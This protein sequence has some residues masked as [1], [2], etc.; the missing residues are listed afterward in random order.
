MPDISTV[1]SYQW[2]MKQSPMYN[3]IRQKPATLRGQINIPTAFYPLFNFHFVLGY[4]PGDQTGTNTVY[5]QLVNFFMSTLGGAGLFLFK[6]PND[7]QVTNQVIATGDGSSV[8]YD[9]VRTYVTG[10]A[11]HLI[12]NFITP[13]SI[14]VDGVLKTVTIDYTIDP[15]YGVLTFVTPPALGKVISWS[16]Q[17]YY[18]CNFDGDTLESLEQVVYQVWKVGEWKF[19][20][21]LN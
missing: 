18:L 11:Q 12:Q 2:S 14:Y 6:N 7:Y 15:V 17:Y 9:M 4:I 21:H 13:P 5:Q 20:S 1:L 19:T 16:G 10:G 3:T 8:A